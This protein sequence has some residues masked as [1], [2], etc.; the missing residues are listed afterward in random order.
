MM[1]LCIAIQQCREVGDSADRGFYYT[2]DSIF[3]LYTKDDIK[4]VEIAVNK[5]F[6]KKV[7]KDNK[8]Y[9]GKRKDY[10]KKI[11]GNIYL[12][13]DHLLKTIEAVE[14][15]TNSQGSNI[16]EYL[17]AYMIS[18]RDTQGTV[19]FSGYFIPVIK[20]SNFRDSVYKYPI[21]KQPEVELCIDEKAAGQDT[22]VV[23][24]LQ[25]AWASSLI[26]IFHMQI[27]G[28][29][30]IEF[31]DGEKEMLVYYG[32]YVY[33]PEYLSK[34]LIEK[35]IFTAED[36][37]SG[38]I[39]KWISENPDSLNKVLAIDP[40]D[41][42]FIR[43]RNIPVGIGSVILT[44]GFSVAVDT[45][46]IPAGSVLLAEIVM[47]DEQGNK[48]KDLRLLFVQDTGK[49]VKGPGMADMFFGVG[50]ESGK[51]ARMFHAEGRL[52]LLAAKTDTR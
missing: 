27:E 17:D 25:V 11:Y 22:S 10:E 29:G 3:Q 14:E 31:P 33:S 43:S 48:K 36:M 5:N 32:D 4:S 39:M 26:D 24:G 16:S 21:Y 20:V 15:W 46:H 8:E 34:Y 23:T 50:A 35:G 7:I 1:F 18:G 2:E 42:F 51:K 37:S 45:S 49:S 44:E 47:T 12:S 30:F 19:D 13:N 52:W 9:L 41:I 40:A 38:K 6:V 28:A